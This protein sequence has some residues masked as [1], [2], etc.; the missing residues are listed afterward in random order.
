MVLRQ[1]G[2]P[3][4]WPSHLHWTREKLWACPGQ[5]TGAGRPKGPVSAE[6]KQPRRL[7]EGKEATSE[8]TEHG[9]V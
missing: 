1:P 2:H 7:K 9:M 6:R 4:S 5:A 8:K 3:T